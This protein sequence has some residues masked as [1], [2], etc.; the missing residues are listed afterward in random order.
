MAGWAFQLLGADGVTPL[1]TNADGAALVSSVA[2]TG[3]AYALGAK[4]GTL[5]AALAANASVFA[6]RL[7]PGYAGKAYIDAV[8]LRFT[9]IVAFTTPI[10]A[11][12]SLVLSRGAGAGTSDGTTISAAPKNDTSYGA[13]NFDVA[14]GGIISIAT[15]AALTVT[16]ITFE[17]TPL[18][19]MTLAHVGAAG[20]FYEHVYEFSS[21]AHPI[22]INAGEVLAVRVGASAMDA[23]GTWV[24]GVEARWR[25]STSEG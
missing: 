6:M 9:T 10:T 12:R 3:N 16:G 15:T 19:E 22:E 18:G 8:K 7:N 20:A 25:E 2:P 1:K 24:L 13:S 17:S 21:R 14:T 5:G 23:A 11:T 4:T